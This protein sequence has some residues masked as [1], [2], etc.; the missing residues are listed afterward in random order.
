[1]LVL[2]LCGLLE[3]RCGSFTRLE[4]AATCS[5]CFVASNSTKLVCE[6]RL[7][8]CMS[9]ALHRAFFTIFMRYLIFLNLN[10]RFKCLYIHLWHF[11]S[12]VQIHQCLLLI[13]LYILLMS[14]VKFLKIYIHIFVYYIIFVFIYYLRKL[15]YDGVHIF[16][17][18]IILFFILDTIYYDTT[19]IKQIAFFNMLI[20]YVN[21]SFTSF[22]SHRPLFAL[23]AE[24]KQDSSISPAVFLIKLSQIELSFQSLPDRWSAVV[25]VCVRARAWRG[26][27]A[28][29]RH[30]LHPHLHLAAARN[31][32][33]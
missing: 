14:R 16:C 1:M 10:K 13:L 31:P 25:C 8:I 23:S 4:T 3:L 21:M 30:L 15:S 7:G 27:A 29:T 20:E 24:L 9:G 2:L 12:R 6:Y 5:R 17:C 28:A 26:R 11:V 18:C 33:K 19:A 32:I 22:S